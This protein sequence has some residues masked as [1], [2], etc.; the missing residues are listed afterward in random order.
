MEHQGPGHR[1]IL[2]HAAEFTQFE[3]QTIQVDIT[4][5]FEI[6]G[7]E[8]FSVEASIVTSTPTLQ[9]SGVAKGKKPTIKAVA[10]DIQIE[11]EDI[12]IEV[13]VNFPA[14][15][16]VDVNVT[17]TCSNGNIDPP[18][19]DQKTATKMTTNGV[20]NFDLVNYL[21]GVT[22]V[23]FQSDGPPPGFEQVFTDCD[24]GLSDENAVCSI[25]N[26]PIRAVAVPVLPKYILA[27]LVLLMLGVG[28]TG[29]R[30][31]I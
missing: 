8:A 27:L 29:I 12:G 18:P 7:L 26:V 22:C 16:E 2:Y 17:L 20:A 19:L 1:C 14:G 11:D 25:Q 3:I 30:R 21:P 5:D 10:D 28:T 23:A 13:H 31:L 6:E 9:Q 4:N 15:G 24:P